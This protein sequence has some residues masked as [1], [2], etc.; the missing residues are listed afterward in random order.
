VAAEKLLNM[1][2]GKKEVSAVLPWKL[3][4]RDSVR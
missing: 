4:E 3:V 1:M 2:A